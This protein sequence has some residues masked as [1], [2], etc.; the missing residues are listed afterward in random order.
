MADNRLKPRERK[1]LYIAPL[2]IGAMILAVLLVVFVVLPAGQPPPMV[3]GAP[4]SLPDV[5]SHAMAAITPP[6]PPLTRAELIDGAR[7]AAAHFA[8][9]ETVPGGD[10]LAGRQY[11]IR[12]PFACDG[13]QSAPTDQV[14]LSMNPAGQSITLAARPGDW[15]GMPVLQTKT[16]A[17]QPETA[18]GF[19]IPRPWSLTGQCPSRRDYPVPVTPTPATAQTLGLVQISTSSD[20]RVGQHGDHAYEFTRKIAAGDAAVLGHSYRL[21]LEGRVTGFG[22]GKAVHCWAESPDH[23]P[24]CFYAVSFDHVAFEDAETGKVLANWTD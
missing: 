12:I 5:P 2:I 18:S 8:A 3:K 24:Q 20:S 17:D 7:Q 14:A 23:H 4:P 15:T 10:A 9:G 11:S 22:D 19:W 16:G 1:L 6:L 21:L 13:V